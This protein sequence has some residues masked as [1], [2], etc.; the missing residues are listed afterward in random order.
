M[1]RPALSGGRS[2]RVMA[3]EA[4]V[5]PAGA[6]RE[7]MARLW[8]CT[9]RQVELLAQEGI[10]V[11]IARDDYDA[12]QSTH[13]YPPTPVRPV[14]KKPVVHPPWVISRSCRHLH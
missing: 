7:D 4:N 1:S 12:P 2:R 3:Q 5:A 6:S 14:E 11:R 13:N 10:A 8:D 9:P